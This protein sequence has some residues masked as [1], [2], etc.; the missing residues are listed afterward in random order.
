MMGPSVVWGAMPT[1]FR[2]KATSSPALC[3]SGKNVRVATFRLGS[4]PRGDCPETTPV[5]LV[6]T[7]E[8][9]KKDP[10]VK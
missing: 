10:V 1:I 7:R 8:T 2:T 5:H 3:F 4:G 9:S 6:E